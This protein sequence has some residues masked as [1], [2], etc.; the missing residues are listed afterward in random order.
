M[1]IK[2]KFSIGETVYYATTTHVTRRAECP[3]CLGQK[4]WKAISPAGDE[5][6]FSCPRCC[7]SYSNDLEYHVRHP[8]VRQLTIGSVRID[9]ADKEK[10]ISYM[11]Q[12]T[13]VG[14]GS[15]YDEA[16]F[17][18]TEDQAFEAANIKANFE[19]AADPAAI[20]RYNKTLSLSL[21]QLSGK[22]NLEK[23]AKTNFCPSPG[24]RKS[25]EQLMNSLTEEM[26]ERSCVKTL[27]RVFTRG[28][29]ASSSE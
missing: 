4:E 9:T 25:W 3:D 20:K 7:K 16:D 15:I 21:Y 17:F 27:N 26:K 29:S 14:S 19:T 23:L 12:E 10:P 5:F 6:T 2:S 11:C 22:Q 18:S 8:S 28:L 24:Q 1:E 13:G